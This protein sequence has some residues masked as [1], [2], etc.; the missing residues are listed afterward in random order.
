MKDVAIIGAGPA[1]IAA[2]I[3]A[4]R[5]GLRVLLFDASFGGAIIGAPE[6][7]NLPGFISISGT[8][9]VDRFREQIEKLKVNYV[10]ASVK[11]ISQKEKFFE[12]LAEKNYQVKSIILGQGMKRRKLKVPGEKKF[13][14]KG[15][16]FC[17]TCDGPLFAEKTVIV[18]GGGDAGVAAATFLSQVAR[19]VYLVEI[20]PKL[21]A[22]KSR[23]LN[24]KKTKTEIILKNSIKE[25]QGKDFVEKIKL[26]RP[27]KGKT[28]LEIDGVFVEIGSVPRKKLVQKLGINTD[29]KGFIK[30]DSGGRT[31]LEGIFAAGDSTTGSDYFWQA[32]PAMAEGAIAAHSCFKYLQSKS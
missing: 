32:L 16:S 21:L 14:Q 22:E 10:S 15:I 9:L 17:A 24:L 29:Q 3:Y 25:I 23:V 11:N 7:G 19:K 6:V 18:V 5:Y 2:A 31:N 28:E 1:G 12:I 13:Y 20:S 26:V 30:I 8:E 27:Y 4:R